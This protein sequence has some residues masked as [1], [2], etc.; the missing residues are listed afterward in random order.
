MVV[1]FCIGFCTPVCSQDKVYLDSLGPHNGQIKQAGNY[2]VE[3]LFSSQNTYVYLY[4]KHRIP[5]ENNAVTGKMIFKQYDSTTAIV[6]LKPFHTDAFVG[7]TDFPNYY[8]CTIIVDTKDAR[9]STK[10]EF[11][12]SIA[13]EN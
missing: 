2:F 8:S 12:E 4:D 11:V 13:D 1:S 10:F 7:K 9:I 6:E 5:L 3:L